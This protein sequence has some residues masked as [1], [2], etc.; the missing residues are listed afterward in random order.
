MRAHRTLPRGAAPATVLAIA[1]A[2]A[3]A[4]VLPA[5]DPIPGRSTARPV[6]IVG[7]TIHPVDAPVIEGGTIVFERGRIVALGRDVAVPAGAERI[8]AAGKHVYPGLIAASTELGLIE[9]ESVRAT[10]DQTEV[11]EMNPNVRAEVSVNPDS[12]HIPVARANG[13]ALAVTRPSG[14]RISGSS[15]LI[16]LDGWTWED[17]TIRAPLG[18]EVSWPY[19]AAGGRGRRGRG[20]PGTAERA[21]NEREVIVARIDETFAAAEAYARARPQREAIAGDGDAPDLRMEALRPA[22][23]GE[24]PVFLQAE[25]E[26]QIRS[27]VEWAIG[28]K[29]KPI[30]VGGRDAPEV[31]EYLAERQV[32]VIYGP[33]HRL[34]ARR[35]EDFAA[36]FSGP[37][38]LHAAGVR[39]AIGAFDT[40][41]VRN[42]PYQAACAAAHGL[43]KEEALRSITLSVA[44]ILGVADRYGSLAAGKSATLIITDGDP[45]EIPTQ[46]EAMWIDGARVDLSSRHTQL[47]EKYSERLKRREPSSQF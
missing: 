18:I 39:F 15:A 29:L 46:V 44:E 33:V 24:I 47:F 12:E 20:A 3:I 26:R 41:N 34:P 45:L 17:L 22:I 40:S 19:L 31:A 16:R 38:R 35:D 36:P 9:I 10:R 30:I 8:D 1:A 27:A 28:R 25:D 11:G 32:P 43:P 7:A 21:E 2:L 23:S 37:G 4:E 6:A 14:G 42:L 13:I 5:S